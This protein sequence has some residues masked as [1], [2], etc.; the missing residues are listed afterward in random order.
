MT[1]DNLFLKYWA[2]T[3]AIDYDIVDELNRIN[4]AAM[5]P[6]EILKVENWLITK[7]TVHDSPFKKKFITFHA[8][9]EIDGEKYTQKIRIY[10][11]KLP[12]V[13]RLQQYLGSEIIGINLICSTKIRKDTI[14]IA[15]FIK[16]LKED[17]KKSNPIMDH[18][19]NTS[20][21]VA[22]TISIE[23]EDHQMHDAMT[24]EM[25]VKRYFDKRYGNKLLKNPPKNVN[26]T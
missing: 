25:I 1:V 11:P 6:K 2:K 13:K 17:G 10:S 5:F 14:L 19:E 15:R 21:L 12:R 26:R 8:Q 9:C 24:S 22:K 23:S 16:I 18:V 3:L 20:P 7:I 4:I